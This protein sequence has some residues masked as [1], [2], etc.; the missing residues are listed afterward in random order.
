[1]LKDMGLDS[2][3]SNVH[4]GDAVSLTLDYF[5]GDYRPI[6]DTM[7]QHLSTMSKSLYNGNIPRMQTNIRPFEPL[8][9][10]YAYDQLNRIIE[11]DY[12]YYTN[13]DTAL[14]ATADYYSHYG[15]DPDGNLQSLLRH[16]NNPTAQ[17]MDSIN[18]YYESGHNNRLR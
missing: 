9:A 18:Y 14:T 6:G 5:K 1:T 13:E 7:V 2:W 17:L 15:Y 10:Q 4:A 11:A 3:T 16:G 8:S 12:A